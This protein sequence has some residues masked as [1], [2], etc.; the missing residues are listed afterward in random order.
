[1]A[2]PCKWRQH[3][4][5]NRIYFQNMTN[6]EV[7]KRLKKNDVILV[8]EGSTENHGSNAPFG[9]DTCLYTQLC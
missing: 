8:P 9:E 1:M 5:A 3:E 6:R 7:T 4:S 2:N